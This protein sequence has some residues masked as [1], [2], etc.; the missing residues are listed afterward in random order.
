MPLTTLNLSGCRGVRDLSPLES[1]KLKE[2]AL[3]PQ[4][5]EGMAVL[6]RV[7]SITQINNVPAD[8]FWKK[9]DAGEFKQYR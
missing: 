6:R 7:K 9:Y 2:I 1:I 3:P 5:A 4:V 8:E